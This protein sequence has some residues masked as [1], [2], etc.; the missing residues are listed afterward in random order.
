MLKSVKILLLTISLVLLFTS[1][2]LAA[3]ITP[4]T[5]RA[6][7]SSTEIQPITIVD[8]ILDEYDNIVEYEDNYYSEDDT[9]EISSG[10]FG[11]NPDSVKP[12]PVKT[13]DDS[14]VDKISPMSLKITSLIQTIGVAVSVFILL[15]ICLLLGIIYMVKSKSTKARFIGFIIISIPILLFIISYMIPFFYELAN[16]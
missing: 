11:F 7:S 13:H 3:S 2:S 4:D 10:G 12:Y 16:M 1:I 5:V 6:P 15:P 14:S 9:E 8:S